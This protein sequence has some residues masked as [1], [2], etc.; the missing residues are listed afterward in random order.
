MQ[1]SGNVYLQRLVEVDH[2]AT[3]PATSPTAPNA[4]V[5]RFRFRPAPSNSAYSS[6]LWMSRLASSTRARRVE[7]IPA[8]VARE[9]V[10]REN[11]L[12]RKS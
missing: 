3:M 4:A 7:D 12:G 10:T 6:R 2:L 9:A 11:V 1:N 8:S 5:Q